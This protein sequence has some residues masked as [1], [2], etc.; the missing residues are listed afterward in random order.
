M[1]QDIAA[2]LIAFR[3]VHTTSCL[4]SECIFALARE[5]NDFEDFTFKSLLRV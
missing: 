2:Y 1:T 5:G 3:G 4:T